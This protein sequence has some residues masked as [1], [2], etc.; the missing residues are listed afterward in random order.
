MARSQKADPRLAHQPEHVP[1]EVAP[2]LRRRRPQ[3]D[4][5]DRIGRSAQL[6]HALLDE[7]AQRGQDACLFALHLALRHLQ[8]VALCDE[9]ARL[10]EIVD[11]LALVA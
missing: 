5:I 3:V 2:Q 4:V 7:L 11:P 8:T 6:G 10:H 9:T 1:V